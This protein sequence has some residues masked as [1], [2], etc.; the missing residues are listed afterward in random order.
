MGAV[1]RLENPPGPRHWNPFGSL[2]EFRRDPLA[3]VERVA[4]SYGPV[5][6]F[7]F[8]RTDAYLVT[9]PELV[10]EVLVTRHREFIKSRL[11]Q[12]SR[13]L[14]G[15]G[16]LT[17]EH[18][19]HLRQRR[20]IQPS[21]HRD[22]IAQYGAQMIE[23]A[24]ALAASLSDGGAIDISREMNQLTLA[25]AG[26]T[27]LGSHVARDDAAQIGDSLTTALGLFE[28]L[29]NPLGPLLDRLPVRSTRRL[30][31]AREDLD[32]RIHG[33]IESRRKN[34]HEGEDL[35]STLLVAQDVEGDGGGM[36]N[37]QIRDEILTI[38]LAGHETTA[39]ALA[40]TWVLLSRYPEAE[41]QLHRE[42]DSVLGGR[43]VE[44]S[45]YGRLPYTRAVIA[46]SM[47]LYP[48]AWSIGRQPLE[49]MELGGYRI[50]AGSIL[51][52][53]PWIT[54]RDPRW[55]DAP[56][57]FMPERWLDDLE[58]RLPRCAYMPF[59]AGPR[60]CIG[61]GFAWMEEVL[62]LAVL[63]SKWK[64]AVADPDEVTPRPLITL[65]LRGD[66]PAVVE[67]R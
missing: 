40:W 2:L 19:Y 57:R 5:S 44:V 47:R 7:R 22:R 8:V 13:E 15:D 3:F 23:H 63:A 65:R 66:V 1:T 51:L 38:F 16:L 61:E 45:D 17:S 31:A 53:S 12:R 54:H 4:S 14:L 39:N 26:S 43:G 55:Y 29:T 59:S 58:S 32:R 18:E 35:L 46:E 20:M 25:I 24:E 49:D 30:Q 11:L 28:R 9:E 34:A 41:R 36:S 6:H 50:R 33:M 37:E 60:K 64:I 21:F 62:V 56:D 48:P 27:L 42:L 10:R 67:R 52:V